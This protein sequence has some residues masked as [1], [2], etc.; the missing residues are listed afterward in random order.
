[1]T[2]VP[3]EEIRMAAIRFGL[4]GMGRHGM[5]YAQYEMAL[6]H[7]LSSL[8][9]LRACLLVSSRYQWTMSGQ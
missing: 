2:H 4:I 3:A 8:L 6:P 7:N 5:R 9:R 1:M